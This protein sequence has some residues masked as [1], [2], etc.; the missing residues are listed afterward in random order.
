MRVN[1]LLF[2]AA[3]GLGL[4]A[5][6]TTAV[7]VAQGNAALTGVVSSKEE[8]K[9][10]GVVVSARKDGGISTV[11]VVSD[12]NGKYTFPRTHLEPGPYKLTIR[13]SGYELAAPATPTVAAGRTTAADLALTKVADI[14]S[15]LTSM[16]WINSMN[17]TP[18]EKDK[19]VHQLLGCNYC[20]T[21]QRIARTKYTADQFMPVID[22]MVHY[23]ADGT[24]VSNDNRRGKIARVQEPGRDFLEKSPNF[25][26]SPG[27]PRTEIAA[28]F[29]KNNLSGGR[30]AHDF[31]LTPLP[32]PTGA[33]TKVIITEWDI[34]KAQT[35]THDSALDEKNM[36]LWF[37][38]EATN[39]LG[40]FDIKAQTFKEYML[41]DVPK[42]IIPGTRDVDL[43]DEGNPWFPLRND[44]GES[45]LAKFDPK[46]EKA[47]PLEG[48]GSQFIWRGPG[49]K[50]W[51]GFRRIDAKTMKV[52][53]TYSPQAAGV[54]P[55]GA[56]AYAGNAKVDSQGN[57]WMVTQQGPGGV[58]GFD[59]AAG[60]GLWFP[61]EGVQARRGNIDEK[62]RMWYGEYRA[63]K[64]FMFDIPIKKA[65]R[66]DLPKYSG[67]YTSSVPDA[68]GRVY[69]PSNM[70]E[71]LYRLD[72]ATGQ[73]I[74]YLWPTEFDTKKITTLN[75]PAGPVMWFT[76]MRTARVSR[77]EVL[78]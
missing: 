44:K 26:A 31:K 30:T 45:Q 8:G 24:A 68:K 73:Y 77:V 22:R 57:P 27:M 33:A 39:Y 60:K 61:V 42:G 41:P 7:V 29:A 13:A 69:A 67:P 23:Y 78:D 20:H 15:Q 66:W 37:T 43:D 76:N 6:R 52:D 40:K 72:P 51:A 53:G 75:T 54:V 47:T 2:V 71:R 36:I 38:D 25:G 70:S 16:E 55:R 50:I 34:P 3:L 65:Q 28:F 59:V 4:A 21:Y 74:G 5:F 35:S 18:E 17:G 19:I 63:D 32:R 10:E 1:G 49:N 62:D 58:M 46:T 9:M 14:S 64:I 48:V 56:A 12:K 11:S